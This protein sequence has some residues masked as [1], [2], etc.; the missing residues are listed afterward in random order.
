MAKRTALSNLMKDKEARVDNVLP[1]Y[2][3]GTGLGWCAKRERKR[4]KRSASG[5]RK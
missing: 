4:A 5:K 3:Y 1:K 2:N